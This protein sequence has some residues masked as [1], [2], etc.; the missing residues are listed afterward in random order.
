MSAIVIRGSEILNFG[1]GP[2]RPNYYGSDRIRILSGHF[3]IYIYILKKVV[4]YKSVKIKTGTFWPLELLIN[5]KYPDPN[6]YSGSGSV[7]QN[8]RSG[9]RSRRRNNSGFT[10][11]RSTTLI[12]LMQ[13]SD[14]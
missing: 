8:Y 5:R 7:T 4:K 9:F 12:L 2:G 11:S 10:A 3:C 1:S 13:M 6:P 14:S